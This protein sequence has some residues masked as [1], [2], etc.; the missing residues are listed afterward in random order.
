MHLLVLIFLW[1]YFLLLRDYFI[2]ILLLRGNVD[3][4]NLNEYF[5]VYA[6]EE[7]STTRRSQLVTY[8]KYLLR[9]K[10]MPG[11]F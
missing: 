11:K 8:D 10:F 7:D 1:Q 6:L 4:K 3:E 2:Y 5:L 9:Q